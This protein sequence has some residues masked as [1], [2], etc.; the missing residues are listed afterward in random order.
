M[1]NIQFKRIEHK[2]RKKLFLFPVLVLLLLY[3][4]IPSILIN[5][6]SKQLKKANEEIR[7]SEVYAPSTEFY[8]GIAFLQTA[9]SVPGFAFWA[10]AMLD[11]EINKFQ[12]YKDFKLK[13]LVIKRLNLKNVSWKQ[14]NIVKNNSITVLKINSPNSAK[15]EIELPLKLLNEID[16]LYCQKWLKFFTKTNT[17]KKKINVVCK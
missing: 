15:K 12:K 13:K 6:G 17:D 9:S 16:T 14:V 8:N 11:D 1:S 5:K 3:I 2:K 4:A 10:E 7:K